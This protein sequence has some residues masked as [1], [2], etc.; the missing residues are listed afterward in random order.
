[1][2]NVQLLKKYIF[3]C[4]CV[5]V[6][7]CVWEREREHRERERER[8]S[9]GIPGGIGV[10]DGCKLPCG[11]LKTKLGSSARAAVLLTAEPSLLPLMCTF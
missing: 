1:M 9:T 4:I 8:E 3:I 5:C 11:A 10:K 2:G 6:C 7:V